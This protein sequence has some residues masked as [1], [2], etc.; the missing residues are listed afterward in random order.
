M[1][2]VKALKRLKEVMKIYEEIQ[3]QR[4][5]GNSTFLGKMVTAQQKTKVR[6]KNDNESRWKEQNHD[7]TF[8]A[9]SDIHVEIPD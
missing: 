5:K 9:N 1:G 2:H 4:W 3:S 7:P 8:T 6:G